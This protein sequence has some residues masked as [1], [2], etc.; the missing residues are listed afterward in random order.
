MGQNVIGFQQSADG[1]SLQWSVPSSE[2]PRI[3]NDAKMYCNGNTLGGW[4]AEGGPRRRG[5]KVIQ[6]DPI[7][8][9]IPIEPIVYCDFR[10]FR[11]PQKLLGRGNFELMCRSRKS[12]SRGQLELILHTILVTYAHKQFLI[13][14]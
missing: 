13:C 3:L 4:R 11:F 14:A 2:F 12:S 8:P 6:G 7:I 5:S 10:Y 1:N 9:W